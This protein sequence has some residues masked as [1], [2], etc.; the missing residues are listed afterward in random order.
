MVHDK[1]KTGEDLKLAIDSTQKWERDCPE[2]P[3]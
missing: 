1:G 2:W 3:L